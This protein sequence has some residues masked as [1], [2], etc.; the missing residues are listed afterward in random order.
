MLPWG[1][2]AVGYLSYRQY[3]FLRR[4]QPPV[5]VAV[6][7]LAIGTQFPDLI[8][9]PLAWTFGVLPSGRSLAHSLLVLGVVAG[10]LYWVARRRSE[11]TRTALFAFGVG[12]LSHLFADGY[13]V[14]FA[15]ETCVNYL[16]WPLAVC[17]YDET[18]RAIIEFLLAVELADGHLFGLGVTVLAGVV[19][20]FDGAPGLRYLLRKAKRLRR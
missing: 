3:T 11:R 4:R 6:V 5:G 9:K 7:A 15:R 16:V 14:L 13:G 12:W 19:W 18:G 17:P 20:L 1:H 10:L 2:A 8:D